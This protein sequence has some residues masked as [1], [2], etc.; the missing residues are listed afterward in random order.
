MAMAF[1][2]ELTNVNAAWMPQY[3][4]PHQNGTYLV[5]EKGENGYWKVMESHEILFS[6]FCGNPEEN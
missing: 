3:S 2:F 1:Q 6:N 4:Y 5:M